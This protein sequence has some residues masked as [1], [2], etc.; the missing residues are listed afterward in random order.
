MA[1]QVTRQWHD[2]GCVTFNNRHTEEHTGFENTCDVARDLFKALL[3]HPDK[4][5][6]K[7]AAK[8][9]LRAHVGA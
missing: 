1:M 5:K 9:T 2:C 7:C 8:D 4:N 6:A 3:R